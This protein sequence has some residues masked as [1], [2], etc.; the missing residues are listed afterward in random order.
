MKE[1][2]KTCLQLSGTQTP[3]MQD[4]EFMVEFVIENYGNYKL[5]ELKTA[6][7]LLATDKLNV[8][9]HFRASD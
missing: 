7:K 4:F 9:K 5:S 1:L 8:D 2:L 6:F 3:T